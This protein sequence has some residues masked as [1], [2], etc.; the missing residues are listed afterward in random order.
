MSKKLCHKQMNF[1]SFKTKAVVIG[2]VLRKFVYPISNDERDMLFDYLN[3]MDGTL[4]GNVDSI[5]LDYDEFKNVCCNIVQIFPINANKNLARRILVRLDAFEKEENK[6][7]LI[8][9]LVPNVDY[10]DFLI[11]S[12]DDDKELSLAFIILSLKMLNCWFNEID[13]KV[14]NFLQDIKLLQRFKYVKVEVSLEDKRPE[15]KF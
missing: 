6:M 10:I 7:N 13:I 9:L 4:S 15:Y 3:N 11:G 2:D 5:H 8:E 12:K 14:E 1:E